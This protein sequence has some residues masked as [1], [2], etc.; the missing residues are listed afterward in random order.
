M[1][2]PGSLCPR[3]FWQP[4]EDIILAE[5]VRTIRR[6]PT[7]PAAKAPMSG[8]DRRHAPDSGAARA[9]SGSFRTLG[10][11]IEGE[12]LVGGE[13]ELDCGEEVGELVEGASAGYR[14]SHGRLG[15]EPG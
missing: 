12:Q 9:W 1:A 6:R 13:I 7:P 5:V 11:T 4:Y 10:G 8:G 14:G 3:T 2:G 15:G